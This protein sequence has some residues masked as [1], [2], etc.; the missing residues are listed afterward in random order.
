MSSLQQAQEVAG[1]RAITFGVP[2]YGQPPPDMPIPVRLNLCLVALVFAG[3]IALLWLSSQASAWYAV[4]LIGVAFSYLMLTNYALLHEAAHGNLHPNA[5]V[6]YG[7]GVL[8]GLFFPIPFRLMRT[9]HQN[10]HHHNRTD[11]EM[12]DLYYPTD[13]RVL[14]WLQWY[15]LLCGGFWP[16]IPLGA[17]LFAVCPGLLRGQLLKK[18]DR[19]RGVAI[20]SN[21]ERAAIRAMRLELLLILLFFGGLFWLFDLKWQNTLILYACFSFNWSTRQYVGHAFSRRDIVDGAWN[22]RHHPW[23]SWLLLHGEWDLNHHRRPDVSWFYLPGLS[24]RGEPRLAYWRQY[25][26]QWRGPRPCQE[27][28]PQPPEG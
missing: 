15:G 21:L 7:L 5:R 8:T 27:P 16:L 1:C 23:M 4:A 9:T 22:L 18:A 11:H 17:V 24:Q 6:N 25:W 2:N 10:H 3:G 28:E 26:R 12:F 13:N 20:V 19:A 14:K